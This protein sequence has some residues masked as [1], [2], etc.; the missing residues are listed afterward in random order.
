MVEV[1]WK[2]GSS[3]TR[4]ADPVRDKQILRKD[5]R[6]TPSNL[7]SGADGGLDARARQVGLRHSGDIA[8]LLRSAWYAKRRARGY[9]LDILAQTAS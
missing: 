2:I 6:T 7:S 3:D 5:V 4:S 9:T 1:S 8:L